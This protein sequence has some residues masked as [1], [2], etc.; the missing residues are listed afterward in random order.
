MT[1][2]DHRLLRLWKVTAEAKTYCCTFCGGEFVVTL[3]AAAAMP[4]QGK[5]GDQRK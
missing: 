1:A 3:T 4:G 5:L 2:C